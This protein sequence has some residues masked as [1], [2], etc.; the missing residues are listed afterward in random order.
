[1]ISVQEFK[2]IK[3][4]V[5]KDDVDLAAAFNHLE[6]RGALSYVAHAVCQAYLE[7]EAGQPYKKVQPS[8]SAKRTFRRKKDNRYTFSIS[9]DMYDRVRDERIQDSAWFKMLFRR[10]LSIPLD[11]I[12][13]TIR[14]WKHFGKKYAVWDE[15]LG[16]MMNESTVGFCN[17]DIDE[18]TGQAY[19]VPVEL[20]RQL[21]VPVDEESTDE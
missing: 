9:V 11:M 7:E 15:E 8:Y 18:K 21:G 10:Y 16:L 17:G 2:T 4:A 19:E 6:T 3:I 1:M 20:L 5:G 13:E 14:F 12:N